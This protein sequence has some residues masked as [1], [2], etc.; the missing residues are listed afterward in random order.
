MNLKK[1]KKVCAYSLD[2][3]LK[4]YKDKFTEVVVPS[5]TW[6]L[7]LKVSKSNFPHWCSKMRVWS[8][9]LE[10]SVAATVALVEVTFMH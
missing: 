5:I 10:S 9:R 1:K 7:S 8:K 6:F 3:C 4:G 2:V